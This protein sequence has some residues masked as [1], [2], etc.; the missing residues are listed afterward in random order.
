MRILFFAALGAM[1][2]VATTAVGIAPTSV[3]ATPTSTDIGTAARADIPKGPVP[4]AQ[5]IGE[6]ALST[7]TRDNQVAL[8]DFNQWLAEMQ[9]QD[10]SLGY[11]ASVDDPNR[12]TI[13]LLWGAGSELPPVIAA[14]AKTANISLEIK[15]RTMTLTTLQNAALRVMDASGQFKQLGFV[16]ADVVAID[17]AFD[18]ITIEGEWDGSNPTRV[19]STIQTVAQ[20]LTG[21]PVAV[22]PGI[23]ASPALGR[24]TIT[25]HSMRVD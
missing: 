22:K 18:G 24:A 3:A 8:M 7:A 20:K 19:D 25:P 2:L 16:V 4:I 11:V 12:R 5:A 1:E 23:T 15:N 6:D 13:T 10:A 17:P 21:T 14:K 9:Q